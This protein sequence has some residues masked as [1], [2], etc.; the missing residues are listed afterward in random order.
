MNINSAV[1]ILDIY[2]F[3]V[4]SDQL[5]GFTLSSA[6]FFLG[7]VGFYGNFSTVNIQPVRTRFNLPLTI[8]IAGMGNGGTTYSF[9]ITGQKSLFLSA[10]GT[11]VRSCNI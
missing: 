2:N 11:G 6:S 4:I 5:V 9:I 3:H 7:I 10:A 1:G 8:P